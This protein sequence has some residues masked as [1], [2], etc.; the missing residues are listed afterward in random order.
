MITGAT[1]MIGSRIALRLAASGITVNAL[2]RSE[3]KAAKMLK[4]P[5][6]RIITGAMDDPEVLSVA[7]QGCDSVFHLAAYARAWHRDSQHYF[8]INVDGTALLIQQAAKAGVQRMVVTSTAG[9]LGPSE[10]MPIDETSPKSSGFFTWYEESKYKMEEL[11]RGLPDGGMRVVIVNPSR[12]YGAAPIQ[13][14]NSV[15]RLIVQYLKGKWR[16]LPGNGLSYGNYAFL[17]DVVEGH[18]LALEK[19]RH[20]ERYI[21]GGGNMSY[22][23]L[24]RRAG[25]IKGVKYRLFPFPLSLMI[26]F[27]GTLKGIGAVTGSQPMITPGWIRKYHHHWNLSNKKAQEELGYTITPYEEGVKKIIEYFNL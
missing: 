10:S 18:I 25:A 1:G 3:S 4:H 23:E 24:F 7:L 9:V 22:L 26:S 17:D 14:S 27:A 6:I 11:V 2:C 21:L 15:T 5:N 13:E 20:R 16:M 8:R 12:L 19:G